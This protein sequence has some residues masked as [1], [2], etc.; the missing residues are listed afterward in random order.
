MRNAGIATLM[1]LL[2]SAALVSCAPTVT[3][4]MVT[5]TPAHSPTSPPAPTTEASAAQTPLA[6]IPLSNT[7]ADRI[8]LLQTLGP[9][10]SRVTDLAF[11][12]DGTRLAVAGGAGT[13]H[14]WDL[15]S[16]SETSLFH[17]HNTGSWGVLFSPNGELLAAVGGDV[18]KVWEIESG[19]ELHTLTG[20][21]EFLLGAAFSPDGALLATAGTDHA[22][23]IWDMATGEELRTLSGHTG[24]VFSVTFSPDGLRLASASGIPD[25]TV[26]LWDVASGQ[27]V[28]TLSGH[29]GDVHDL[30]LSP[31]GTLLVSGGTDRT[32]RLWDVE[33]GEVL[34][35]L[36]GYRD[37]VYGLAYS[38]DGSLAAAATGSDR[39]ITLW[40]TQSGQVARTL[41][42]HSDEVNGVAFS[43][44]GTLLASGENDGTVFLWGTAPLLLLSHGPQTFGNVQTYQVGLGDLDG[45]GDLDA[46]SANMARN[47]SRVWLNDGTGSFTDTGQRLTQE[48]HGVGVGDLDGDGD[49]D[50]FM[51]CASS[52]T[53]GDERALP[54]RVYLNDGTGSF[55][56]SGQDLGDNNLSGNHVN[57]VDLDSD[58]D[59]DA[60]VVYYQE[61]DLVYLNDGSA[62]FTESG[63]AIPEYST[64]GD[65]DSD[66]DID[67]FAKD[68][69]QGYRV[70]LNDGAGILSE[71]WHMPDVNVLHGG[72]ALADFDDDGDLDAFVTNGLRSPD[73]PTLVLLNDGAGSFT[74]SGQRLS[75]TNGASLGT[76]DL[77]GDGHIDV[78]ISN[79]QRSNQVW[80]ND[81]TG[82]FLFSGLNLGEDDPTTEVSLGDLDNDGDLDVII[83]S[84]GGDVQIWFNGSE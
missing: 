60:H 38:P 54:S 40:D 12:P 66:G 65:L 80:I 2:L 57:L 75:A 69:E 64:W 19:G 52:G 59:L 29:G 41:G 14:L 46:V 81:G 25:S 68:V 8:E 73:Y 22:I 45:D 58:G 36:R 56:D 28:Q 13:V 72:V 15:S 39:A 3:T 84:F 31:D 47:D 10:A 43:P 77:N 61:P 18:L 21:G 16:G 42:G 55:H 78:F 4:V 27:V 67:V 53:Y 37:V 49:L 76:G 6:E 35:T 11:S 9:I 50:L 5:A 70:Y 20:H 71:Y 79:F 23:K 26:R 48:G 24:N 34:H 62:V 51:T 30:A 7:N 74:D 82:R 83:G 44:D 32:A 33:S 63:L 1:V 17:V